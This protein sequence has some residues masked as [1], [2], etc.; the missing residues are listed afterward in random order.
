MKEKGKFDV[1]WTFIVVMCVILGAIGTSTYSKRNIPSSN[2]KISFDFDMNNWEFDSQKNIY[3]KMGVEYCENSKKEENE[4]FE[5][6]VPGEYLIGEPNEDGK[7]NCKINKKGMKSGYNPETSPMIIAIQSEE[8]VE[9]KL[10]EKYNYEEISKFINEGYIYIWPGTR[11]QTEPN[12]EDNEGYSKGIIDGII[13]LK[14]LI[15]FCRFNKDIMP[16]NEE[17][18]IS[19]GING[20][21][22]KSAILG[23]SG[24][25]DLYYQKLATIGAISEN[26]EGKRIS[27][28]VNGAMCCSPIIDIDTIEKNYAWFTGQYINNEDKE[29]IND[30]AVQYAEYINNL[31]LKD[32]YGSLLYLKETD[33][34]IYTEGTYINYIMSIYEN[35]INKFIKGTS[36]PYTNNEKSITYNTVKDYID[37]LNSKNDYI[38]YDENLNI[39]KIKNLKEFGLSFENTN[40]NKKVSKN[41]YNPVYFLS[42]KYNGNGTS[43]ISRH[44]NIFNILNENDLNDF[45]TMNLKLLLQK[46]EDV[47]KINYNDVWGRDYTKEEIKNMEFENLKSWIK[48]W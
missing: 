24:D 42:N 34:G 3:Y 47:N 25:S 1:I 37:S 26:N 15:K 13:D 17:K 11:G 4:K 44:W 21:G 41:L 16:G 46:N 5:I 48:S 19:Y 29:E 40:L 38:S 8:S 23:A 12:I 22:T 9:Q 39:A 32:E 20:G 28:S 36:F 27:D 33:K 2:S 35:S 45:S 43:Y 14:A 31:K 18:I 10:H 6:Y 7:Y 30:L